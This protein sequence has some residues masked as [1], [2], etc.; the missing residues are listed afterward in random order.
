MSKGGVARTIIYIMGLSLISGCGSPPLEFREVK[1]APNSQEQ[2]RY[3]IRGIN[4]DKIKTELGGWSFRWRNLNSKHHLY[5]LYD[6]S[7]EEILKAFP[8]TVLSKNQVRQIHEMTS[9]SSFQDDLRK[10]PLD[11]EG[12]PLGF[13]SK[14]DTDSSVVP[15]DLFNFN[16]VDLEPNQGAFQQI[17]FRQPDLAQKQEWKKQ[18]SGCYQGGSPQ[19]LP[20][21]AITTLNPLPA[22]PKY[23]YIFKVGDVLR[24]TAKNSQPGL[25]IGR[26]RSL[27]AATWFFQSPLGS[28]IKQQVYYGE[29]LEVKLDT[30]GK[31]SVTLFIR[32]ENNLCAETAARHFLVTANPPYKM[33]ETDP[34]FDS[35][36]E[37]F[38]MSRF[39]H[40]DRVYARESWEHS[41]GEGVVIAIIDTGVNYLHPF[42]AHNIKTNSGEIPGNDDD[43]D[44]NGYVDDYIGFDYFH[45]D[46]YPF[47]DDGHGSHVAGLAVGP[48]GLARKAKILPLKVGGFGSIDIDATVAA[49]YYAVD[50]GARVINL[51]MVFTQLNPQWEKAIQYAKEA[52]V[53]IV[54]GAGNGTRRYS[55][56]EMTCSGLPNTGSGDAGNGFRRH[57]LPVLQ[58]LPVNLDQFPIYPVSYEASNIISVAATGAGPFLASYSNYG[59]ES[60]DIAAPGGDSHWGEGLSSELGMTMKVGR[61][62]KLCF[63]W[64]GD[65]SSGLGQM[66][67]EPIFSLYAHNPEGIMFFGAHGTSA[68]APIVAGVAAQILS[69]NPDLSAEEVIDIIISTGDTHPSLVDK[70]KSGRSVNA[71]K[72][73]LKAKTTLISGL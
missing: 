68:S 15:V 60:V 54:A 55:I 4:L 62:K 33:P 7:R 2:A 10:I 65:I 57:F 5:E 39:H 28:R 52:G 69:I 66:M 31:Y 67:K 36:E 51:S 26:R 47:D 34:I 37:N 23:G 72:A 40:L 43:D 20:K 32:D 71:L 11:L 56:K 41:Q 42:L 59:K 61:K 1:E 63:F 53:V 18:T 14:K 45:K 46:S 29:N 19:L 27:M 3:L 35:I 17:N 25:R 13:G 73:V 64:E 24:L 8:H 22:H 21:P 30:M 12:V 38:D 9:P 48:I 16:W 49:I 70:V 44:E 58:V 50:Q 6:L